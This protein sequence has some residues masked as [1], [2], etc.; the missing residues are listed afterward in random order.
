VYGK[1]FFFSLKKGI[2]H[3]SLP[4]PA[5]ALLSPIPNIFYSLLLNHIIQ[6]IETTNSTRNKRVCASIKSE[7]GHRK[8]AEKT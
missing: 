5:P 3:F 4:P 2:S 8:A 7:K 1:I 6:F